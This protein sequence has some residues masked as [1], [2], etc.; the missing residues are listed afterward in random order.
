M[1]LNAMGAWIMPG[2]PSAAVQLKT[3]KGFKSNSNQIELSQIKQAQQSITS[4]QIY[5]DIFAARGG[6]QRNFPVKVKLDLVSCSCWEFFSEFQKL[7]EKKR[8]CGN[9]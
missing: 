6:A 3:W 9:F 5:F 4:D 1:Y 2:S 8:K 7:V